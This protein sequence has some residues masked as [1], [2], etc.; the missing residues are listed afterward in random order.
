MA[1]FGDR[2]IVM[3]HGSIEQI[4]T[5]EAIYNRP[6]SRFVADFVGSA[7]LIGGRLK[8]APN[9]PSPVLFETERGVLLQAK[10]SHRERYGA[11]DGH[12]GPLMPLSQ[13]TTMSDSRKLT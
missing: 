6:K 3:N 10:A 13:C 1:V 9:G 4:G 12:G 5:P 8:S 7:N 2:V 11:V